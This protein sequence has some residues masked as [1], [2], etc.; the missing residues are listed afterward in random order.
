MAEKSIDFSFRNK[1]YTMELSIGKM[2]VSEK[3]MEAVFMLLNM[4]QERKDISLVL[5]LED[6]TVE[7]D[8]PQVILLADSADG[9]YMELS[10]SM[11]E[12]KWYHPLILANDHLNKAEVVAVLESIL[13]KCTDQIPLI[14]NGFGE[15]SSR[16]YPE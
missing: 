9:F 16:L 1:D 12:W 2:P 8:V 13:C 6:E 4:V 7:D 11:E 15:I 5:H 3:Q 14:E 10:Y